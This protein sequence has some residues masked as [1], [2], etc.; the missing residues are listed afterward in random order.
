[1]YGWAF[2]YLVISL[3]L[4]AFAEGASDNPSA[5]LPSFVFWI[6]FPIVAN[7]LYHNNVKRRISAALHTI[8]EE[9]K[10]L[11]YLRKEGGVHMWVIWVFCGIPIFWILF[12][13]LIP[14]IT[15]N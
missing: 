6:S 2:I 7:S 15:R 5:F 9:K 3:I 13:I 11:A 1:M 10:L 14:M 4:S 12:A 8:K